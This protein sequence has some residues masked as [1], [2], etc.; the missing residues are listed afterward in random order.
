VNGSKEFVDLFRIVVAFQRDKAIADN[1][2]ML[3]CFRLEKLKDFV[4]HRFVKRPGA[5]K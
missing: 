5:S 2:E 4:R 3:L 1:L